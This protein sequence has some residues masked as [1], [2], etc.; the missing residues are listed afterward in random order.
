VKI[1]SNVHQIPIRLRVVESA[2]LNK[3][4]ASTGCIAACRCEPHTH[5]KGC[6]SATPTHP[7]VDG[8]PMGEQGVD[9]WNGRLGHGLVQQGGLAARG[10]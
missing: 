5:S 7:E 4:P 1:D 2:K 9:Q 8:G 6:W 3:A 10:L